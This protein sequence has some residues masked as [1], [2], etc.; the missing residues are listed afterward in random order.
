MTSTTKCVSSLQD[1]NGEDVDLPYYGKLVDII[2]LNYSGR[3]VTLFKCNWA[4]TTSNRGFLKDVWGFN[5]V[6]FSQLIH[7]GEREEHE[8][9][10]EASQA[11]MV[12]YVDDEIAKGWSVVVHLKPKDF[13]DMGEEIDDET[14]EH[15]P[16]VEQELSKFF[17]N[18]DKNIQL[19]RDDI[20]DN[21]INE[22]F[23]EDGNMS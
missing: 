17:G 16:F 18:D 1:V 2:E 6:N 7:T 11:Q 5:L 15:E 10:I 22:N 13:Y 3:F 4:D 14:C 20:D 23:E 12:Y 8:P 9:Y 21:T 19:A